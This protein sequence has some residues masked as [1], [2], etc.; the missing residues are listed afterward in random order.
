MY[1]ES[2]ISVKKFRFFNSKTAIP[3]GN[4]DTEAKSIENAL[5]RAVPVLIGF[6]ASL[7]GI[8]GLA[9]K[10]LVVFCLIFKC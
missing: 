6:L 3:S 8:G 1:L 9:D 5:G 10:I 7:L 2:G 4:V